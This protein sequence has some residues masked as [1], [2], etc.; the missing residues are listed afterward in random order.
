MV[1]YAGQS[2]LEC[3][4]PLQEGIRADIRIYGPALGID[5]ICKIAVGYDRIALDYII[6]ELKIAECSSNED[7]VEKLTLG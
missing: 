5:M 7:E 6:Q 3:E 4:P 1:R 2:L